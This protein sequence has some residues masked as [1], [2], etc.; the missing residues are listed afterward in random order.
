MNVTRGLV[1]DLSIYTTRD[2][3]RFVSA[4][5]QF[6]S[7]L[8]SLSIQSVNDSINQFLSSSLVTVQLLSQ[9]IFHTHID[10][11]IEQSKSNAP[12]IF[13]RLLFLLRAI[14]HGNAIISAYMTNFEYIDP[15][16]DLSDS[17]AITQAVTYGNGCSCASSPNCTTQ[18]GFVNISSSEILPV[19]GLKMGCTPSESFFASTLECFYDSLCI[20]FIQEQINNLNTNNYITNF[21]SPLSSNISQFSINTT[22]MSLVQ[23]LFIENWSTMINYSAYFDLCS[24]ILCSYTYIQQFDSLYTVSV[25]L[26]LYGGLTFILKWICPKITSLVDKIYLY[27]KKR[28][29]IVESVSTIEGTTIE[30]ADTILTPMNVPIESTSISTTDT[31]PYITFLLVSVIIYNYFY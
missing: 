3:R 19:K 24:P 14:N 31:T 7:G 17:V 28:R 22:I 21:A 9:K 12:T 5:L 20:N 16:S 23:E 18:A 30:T 10:L 13:M 25:I 1:A 8:C 4:H 26:G 15:W 29:N 6:L 11:L 2:Y 27:R